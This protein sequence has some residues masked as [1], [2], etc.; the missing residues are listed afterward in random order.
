MYSPMICPMS[1]GFGSALGVP[2][3]GGRL[4]ELKGFDSGQSGLYAEEYLFYFS[5]SITAWSDHQ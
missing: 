2:F 3:T 1:M 4:M 5:K